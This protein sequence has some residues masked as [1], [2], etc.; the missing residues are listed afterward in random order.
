MAGKDNLVPFKKG[1]DARRKGNGRPKG[2]KSLAT[3]IR[4]LENEEF[5][6]NILPTKDREKLEEFVES[7]GPIGSPFRVIVLKA[8]LDS[9]F[10][11]P[12]EKAS[13]REWLRKAGYGD[14]LDVTTKGKKIEAPLVVSTI[15]PR[16]AEPIPETETTTSS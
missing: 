1:Y 4:E 2:S 6:W 11:N 12:T 8:V 14:K 10:G 13:A 5:D 15:K 9:I 7:F 3:I 16:D